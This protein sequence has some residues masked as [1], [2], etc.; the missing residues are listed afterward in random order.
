M[1]VCILPVF[2]LLF[3]VPLYFCTIFY[4]NQSCECWMYVVFPFYNVPHNYTLLFFHFALC[5]FLTLE[6]AESVLS[7]LDSSLYT[8]HFCPW[9]RA[10]FYFNCVSSPLILLFC[11]KICPSFHL[12]LFLNIS[13]LKGPFSFLFF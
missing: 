8:F 10:V 5:E 1:K 12:P 9:S 6:Y 11:L 13:F 3:S 7:S 2:F 4:D